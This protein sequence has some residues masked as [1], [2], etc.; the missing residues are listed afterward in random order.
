MEKRA[1]EATGEWVWTARK[2][3][4]EGEGRLEVRKG[5]EEV[6]SNQTEVLDNVLLWVV[7]G[8][9]VGT[10]RIGRTWRLMGHIRKGRR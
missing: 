9:G 4:V 2:D 1:S 7:W 3:V 8:V 5:G 10:Q 6:T